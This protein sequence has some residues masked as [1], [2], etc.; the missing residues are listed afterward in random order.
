MKVKLRFGH[1]NGKRFYQAGEVMECPENL[2]QSLI[3]QGLAVLYTEKKK[4]PAQPKT[5]PDNA[6]NAGNSDIPAESGSNG[7]GENPAADDK[8]S[9]EETE[10][11]EKVQQ[12]ENPP[13]NTAQSGTGKNAN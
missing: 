2:G 13:Q 9:G 1:H 8:A 6:G 5:A 12:G 4:E 3:R 10:E 7:T 11:N